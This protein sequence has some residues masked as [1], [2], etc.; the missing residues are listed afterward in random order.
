LKKKQIAPL[1]LTQQLLN[2]KGIT[3]PNNLKWSALSKQTAYVTAI[4]QKKLYLE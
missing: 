2:F 1:F 3:T 4:G